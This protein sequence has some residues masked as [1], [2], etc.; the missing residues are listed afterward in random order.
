MAQRTPV[1]TNVI[2]LS[3]SLSSVSFVTGNVPKS[4]IARTFHSRTWR[5]RK[6]KKKTKRTR[7]EK[8]KS[9]RVL[10]EGGNHETAERKNAD[11]RHV[12]RQ[13]P[14]RQKRTLSLSGV[15]PLGHSVSVQRTHGSLRLRIGAPLPVDRAREVGGT[16]GNP[17]S[18]DL[19]LFAGLLARVRVS[20]MFAVACGCTCSGGSTSPDGCTWW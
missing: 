13:L 3:F 7:V 17:L 12:P 5:K 2:S 4:K 6:K 9:N 14:L 8:K 15:G 1:N 19:L 11:E 18:T 20:I 10:A 16:T